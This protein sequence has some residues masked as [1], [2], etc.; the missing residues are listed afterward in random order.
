VVGVAK[1][2]RRRPVQTS[3]KPANEG[4]F[5]PVPSQDSAP[6]AKGWKGVEGRLAR[7]AGWH[8]EG[9]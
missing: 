5:S 8:Q 3:Q 9:R 7:M 4:N 2:R 6:E 1:S